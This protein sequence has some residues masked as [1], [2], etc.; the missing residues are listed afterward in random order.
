MLTSVLK[1]MLQTGRNPNGSL[2]AFGI[3]PVRTA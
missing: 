2:Q 3:W 1:F